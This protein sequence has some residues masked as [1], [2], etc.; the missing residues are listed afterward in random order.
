MPEPPMQRP[1]AI[2]GAGVLGSRIA[3]ALLAGGHRVHIRDPSADALTTAATYI[4]AHRAEFESLLPAPVATGPG[5]YQVFTSL[6]DAV[7]NAWL[8]IEAIPEILD[9]KIAT[10]AELDAHTPDDC[11]LASNSSS[12][13]SRLMGPGVQPAR[14]ARVL[15]MH[16][17]MPPGIRSVELMGCGETDPA[18]FERL[19]E[20]L[21]GCGL[22]PVTARRESTGFIFN[23]LWAAVK[24]EI[25]LILAEDV[26]T[27]AEID[28]LWTEMFQQP[29]SLPPCR[30]MD[31]IGLDTVAFIEDN[32]I[33]ERGLDGSMTVDWLRERYLSTG[34]LGLK[35][36]GGGLY[37]PPATTS[38]D[39][40]SST[41]A[42]TL[43][44]LDVGLGANIP[45]TTPLAQAGRILSFHRTTGKMHPLVTGQSLPDG[46]GYS[47]SAGRIFWTNMGA[48][49]S[50]RDGSVHSANVDGSDIRT[51]IPTGKVHT[52]KQL[53]LD[54]IARKLYFCD[55][56]GMGVHRC[57]FDGSDHEILV[58]TGSA[59]ER[60]DMTRWCVGV[61]LDVGAGY[62]Y[63][64]QK[65]PSKGNQGR[66]CR[67]GI[68]MPVGQTADTRD[69]VEVLLE[70]L[71]EPIDLEVDAPAQRL[72][73]TD[74]GEHPVGCSLNVLDLGDRG[75]GKKV[76]ARHFHEPI[77]L[78]LG[79]EGEV[80]VADLGGSVYSVK[81]GRKTVLWRDEG[82]YTGIARG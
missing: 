41:P 24:R 71:P 79:E 21:R 30:L 42:Q 6:A 61:A 31:Q 37:G 38:S 1:I 68:E 64:T 59:A 58:R 19:S 73:W 65:G 13:K 18:H 69:D 62:V 22:I 54:E 2:L 45:G 48:A 8:V 3:S 75:A 78:C 35:S 5:V 16:F 27:A 76:L 34:K 60:G 50:T 15:N 25:L 56:E 47:P 74:R 82:C 36:T 12:F 46:I 63:W 51:L 77:G 53:T 80:I 20:V 67:A 49:T 10:F 26:S 52:P 33:A 40:S 11:I 28:T 57:H 43:Y 72:Y 17:T 39:P 14:R 44:I 81:G 66:I 9:L 23:R 7:R 55:R 29:H 4:D 70:G 32:Y